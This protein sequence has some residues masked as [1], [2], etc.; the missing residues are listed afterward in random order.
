[1]ATS[2]IKRQNLKKSLFRSFWRYFCGLNCEMVV[3]VKRLNRRGFSTAVTYVWLL[4]QPPW[5][6][7]W[8]SFDQSIPGREQAEIDFSHYMML[9]AFQPQITPKIAPPREPLHACYH[10][11]S[12][13]CYF[14]LRSCQLTFS[15]AN[16]N[17]KDVVTNHVVTSA[18]SWQLNERLWYTVFVAYCPHGTGTDSAAN[19]AFTSKNPGLFL[20]H[21]CF[22]HIL[23]T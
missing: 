23:A 13:N 14:V 21:N 4:L 18:Q 15:F 12:I 16:K 22:H 5:R 7:I 1:M 6:F 3:H 9:V 2:Q 17:L 19:S 11:S 10:I 8:C 20:T